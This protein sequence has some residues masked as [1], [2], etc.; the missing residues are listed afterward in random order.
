[1]KLSIIKIV[2]DTTVDGPGLRT[3][4]YCAG[5]KHRCPGCHN[6]ESWN[7]QCGKDMETDEILRII[8]EDPFA[9][10]T[11]TGGDPMYQAESFAELARAIKQ[12]T[13]K[14]IWCYTGFLYENLMQNPKQKELLKYIDVL[15][16]GPYIESYREESLIFRGSSNQRLIDVPTSLQEKRVALLPYHPYL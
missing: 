14:T 4:I 13:K 2:E 1:M 6:P 9:D 8:L 12:K 3:A 5:C 11:F 15:I 10:I 16:D 7:M